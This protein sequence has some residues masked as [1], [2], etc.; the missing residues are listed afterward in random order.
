[1]RI[2][3]LS[4]LYVRRGVVVEDWSLFNEFDVMVHLFRDEPPAPSIAL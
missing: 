3:G 1:M 4:Q 2:W